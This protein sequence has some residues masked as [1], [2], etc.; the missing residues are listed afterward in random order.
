MR[1]DMRDGKDMRDTNYT[2][3]ISCFLIL[4]LIKRDFS[5]FNNLL[6]LLINIKTKDKTR[7]IN[8]EM[9]KKI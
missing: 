1:K 7:F 3:Y 2:Y 4:L 9:K 6:T 8:K 5:T